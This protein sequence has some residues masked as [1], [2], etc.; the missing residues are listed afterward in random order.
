[1][2]NEKETEKLRDSRRT[3]RKLYDAVGDIL[4][5]EGFSGLGPNNI[6]RYADVHKKL[7]YRYFVGPQE[8][9][10]SYILEKD[11][12]TRSYK[13]IPEIVAANR[14]DF[15][16]KLAGNMLAE[17]LEYFSDSPELQNIILWE[18]NGRSQMMNKIARFRESIKAELFEL[19]DPHFEGSSVNFRAVE[20]LLISGINYLVLHSKN[21]GSNFCELDVK[22]ESDRREIVKAIKQLVGWAFD[23]ADKKG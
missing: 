8:L 16:R 14:H 2:N 5:A 23:A 17:N 11:Y 7:I 4:K 20:A 12:W 6:A 22:K 21:S 1:M 19:T 9:I 10:E 18:I 15:G 13:Q 3:K